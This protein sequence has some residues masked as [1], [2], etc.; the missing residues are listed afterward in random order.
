MNVSRDWA[1]LFSVSTIGPSRKRLG[2]QPAIG[3]IGHGQSMISPMI[4]P[5]ERHCEEIAALCRRYG[6][7]KLEVFGS[8]ACGDFDQVDSDVDLFFDFDADSSGLA[9]R[10]FGLMEDLRNL[11]LLQAANQRRVTLYAA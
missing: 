7:R 9:H 3:A 10:F 4:E 2:S 6:L 8:A 5:L 1:D 11:Y